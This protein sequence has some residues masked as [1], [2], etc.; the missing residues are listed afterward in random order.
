MTKTTATS[1]C[2]KAIASL[3]ARKRHSAAMQK[4]AEAIRIYSNSDIPLSEIAKQFNLSPDA[5]SNYIGRYH[6]DLLLKKYGIES[7]NFSQCLKKREYQSVYTHKK[8]RNAI[9]AC[10]DMAYIEYNISQIAEMFGLNPTALSS[11]LRFHYPDVIPE[12]ERVRQDLGIAD[13]VH[14]GARPQ[15]LEAY[16]DAVAM[17]R[18]TDMTVR[19]V[20]EACNVSFGGL[21]QHLQFYHKSVVKQKA[22]RRKSCAN[23]TDQRQSGTLS[24]NGQICGP[25]PGTV[26]KY[27]KALETYRTSSMT[28]KEIAKTTGVPYEGFRNYLRSWNMRKTNNE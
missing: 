14:R 27:A 26:E 1:S 11:Q 21:R 9:L 2:T 25:K 18:D 19:E 16:A 22:D 28:L 15:C 10:S 7:L 6:R 12:R 4:Y 8:Y 24:G 23:S 17:Y 5:L 13:N 3:S 20:A